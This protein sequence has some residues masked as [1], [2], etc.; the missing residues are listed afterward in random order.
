MKQAGT[1]FVGA[2]NRSRGKKNHLQFKKMLGEIYTT[3][4][5]YRDDDFTLTAPYQGKPNKN[6]LL[7]SFLHTNVNVAN[8]EKR[9]VHPVVF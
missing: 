2:I 1:S 7:L 4:R 5:F 3:V 6:I 8:N 9:K